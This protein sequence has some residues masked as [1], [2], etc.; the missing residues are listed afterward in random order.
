MGKI[1]RRSF[2]YTGAVGLTGYAALSATGLISQGFAPATTTIDKVK[3]GNTGLTVSRVALGTGS[4]GGNHQSNQT[5]LG[6][7]K[8]VQMAHHAYDRGVHFFDTADSYGSYPFV[9]EVFKEV[10][11]E[12]ITLLGKMWTTNDPAKAEPV[13][14]AL[15]RFRTET[16]SDYF[17]I[18]LLHCMTDGKWREEKKR[19]IDYFSKA[20]QDGII[21]A[22]GV[23]CHNFEALK[24]AADDPWVDVIL[25]RINPFQAHMDGTPAEISAVI[26][27]ARK[28]G[29]GI[30]GMKIFGNGDRILENEREE[31]ITF[32]LKKSSIHCMTL[33]M[34]SVAQ[35]DDAVDRVMRILKS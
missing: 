22:V 1:N 25:A 2:I 24:V 12:K 29:K 10:P 35:V 5:R 7:S 6:M 32:A 20:K 27:L 21:K 9:R 14:K 16:G 4:I 8:F 18:M 19:Y 26:E 3:L 28:N 23:S 31:S 34:E 17:D 13:D 30:I 11:R 33:G 15:D